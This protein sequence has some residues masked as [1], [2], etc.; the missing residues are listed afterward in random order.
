MQQQLSCEVPRNLTKA[1]QDLP[2]SHIICGQMD[3]SSSC[4]VSDMPTTRLTK[5]IAFQISCNRDASCNTLHS[6]SHNKTT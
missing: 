1:Y 4:R 5:C 6:V 3:F 2:D